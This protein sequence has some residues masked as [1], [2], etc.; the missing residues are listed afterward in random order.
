MIELSEH[1]KR[2]L[3]SVGHGAYGSELVQIIKKIRDQS[4]SLEGLK[5]GGDHNAEVEGRLLFKE[6]ADELIKNLSFQKRGPRPLDPAD[7][8]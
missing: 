7:F 4:A 1:D 6:F 8:S 2:V 3:S 5:P